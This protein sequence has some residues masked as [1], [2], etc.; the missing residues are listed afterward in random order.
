MGSFAP[1]LVSDGGAGAARTRKRLGF[2]RL[3][4]ETEP[5]SVAVE[6]PQ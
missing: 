2:G 6:D 5:P 1:A 4:V 3:L